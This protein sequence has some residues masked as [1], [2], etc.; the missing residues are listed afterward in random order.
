MGMPI[1]IG[2]M[3]HTHI[4]TASLLAAMLLAGTAA[5]A[6]FQNFEKARYLK[7]P[8]PGRDKGEQVEGSLKFDSAGKHIVF[9]GKQG[10][11]LLSTSYAS[12]KGITYDRTARPRYALGMLIA[13]QFLW[14]KE[15]KHFLTFQ[16]ETD[17]G[18]LKYAIVRLDKRNVQHALALAEA[19]T[20][21]K[22]ERID[23]P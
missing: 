1:Y 10:G 11:D 18:A 21:V 7:P 19:E 3:K 6:D 15:K 12:I 20:R 13:R 8:D 23:E 22:I 9:T 17:G 4:C 16:Y 5:A 14:T 2:R